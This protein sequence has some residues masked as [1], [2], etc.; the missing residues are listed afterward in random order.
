[1]KTRRALWSALLSTGLLLA[2]LVAGGASSCG[3]AE[4]PLRTL[5]HVPA[6][7][8]T[9]DDGTTFN[10]QQLRGNVWIASFLFTSCTSI[11]PTLA[12]QLATLEERTAVHG[13]RVRIVS[14]TVDPEVDTPERLHEFASR[15]RR[16]PTR[17]T[18][19]TGRPDTVNATIRRGFL[20][21]EPE[22]R[23]I[24]QAPGYDV[25]HGAN[26]ML[27]DETGGCRGLYRTDGPGMEQLLHDIERLLP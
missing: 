15:F 27:F 13:D 6:F 3:E 21:P 20:M 1:V 16:D 18:F 23:E 19:L 7:E 12:S 14:I 10:S 4:E 22:R 9:A 17:W 5:F 24:D 11:C 25:M 2:I 8:L 26:V